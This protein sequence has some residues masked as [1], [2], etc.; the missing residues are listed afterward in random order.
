MALSL[1]SSWGGTSDTVYAL[2][3]E[4]DEYIG[5]NTLVGY[6]VD[7][8]PWTNI[9]SVQKARLLLAATRLID[10]A[11][12]YVG[13]RQ[14]FNQTLEFPRVPAGDDIWP[15]VNRTLTAA[16][17]YN[18]YLTEQKRR[19]KQATIEQAYALARDGD[20]DEHT[21]RQIQGI[22]SYSEST[23]PVS[24]SYAY[25]GVVL[26]LCPEAMELLRPYK[27]PGIR[28]LRG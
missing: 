18:I 8:T 11:S 2:L 26:P 15:W 17:T 23:G 4:A 1:I 7:I 28:L 14:F 20:R 16:N 9:G 27:D 25:G 19:V 12:N 22:R 13:D 24:E 6:K 21:K 3:D 10:N 5:S